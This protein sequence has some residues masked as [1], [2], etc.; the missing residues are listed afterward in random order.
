MSPSKSSAL[1]LIVIPVLLLL[2][3]AC[4]VPPAKVGTGIRPDASFSGI[5]G[6]VVAR[7][8][9]TEITAAQLDQAKRIIL[10]NKPG[11]QVPPL[12]QKEFEMQALNQLISSELLYQASAKLEI[13]DL[14]KRVDEKLAEVKKRFPDSQ[15]YAAELQKIGIDEKGMRES[16]RRD[17]SVAYLVNTR[18]APGITVTEEEITAFYDQNPDKF[19]QEEQVKASHILIGVD[20]AAR[21][22]EKKAAREKAEKLHKELVNGADFAT[23]ARE[24][25]TCPSS[26]Q[27][28]E[29]GWFGK[30]RMDSRFEQVAFALK[31]GEV[32]AVVETRFGYH[33]IKLEERRKAEV[34]LLPAARDKIEGYLRAQKTNVAIEVFVGVARKNATIE[35]LL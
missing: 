3:A 22:E 1:P 15:M 18:I 34:I 25:S 35:V 9:G 13:Q 33:I 4:S 20:S 26:R 31:P 19:R 21:P 10:A 8:N 27:G 29:L 12:L 28:G 24:N 11:L 14:D 16:A 2:N 7:V 5:P 6:T 30:G 23:L 17:L 32:S